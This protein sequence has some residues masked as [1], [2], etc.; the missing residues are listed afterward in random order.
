VLEGED[1][2]IG[3]HAAY[4]LAGPARKQDLAGDLLAAGASGGVRVFADLA[5]PSAPQKFNAW[6]LTL[7]V[8][9]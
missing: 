8:A 7:Q 6:R 1:H 9:H 3:E 5:P 2:T 4:R